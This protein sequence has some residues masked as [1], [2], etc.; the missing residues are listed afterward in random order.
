MFAIIPCASA[1]ATLFCEILKTSDGFVALRAEPNPNARLIARMHVGD[2]VLVDDTPNKPK[3]W[4][5]FTWWKGGRF[6][7]KHEYGYDKP[8]AVGWAFDRYVGDTCG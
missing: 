4:T 6:K 7:A 2:E 3:G 5:H 8:N 1:S